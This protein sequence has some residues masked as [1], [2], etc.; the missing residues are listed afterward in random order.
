MKISTPA[1]CRQCKGELKDQ[2]Q[3]NQVSTWYCSDQC[4]EDHKKRTVAPKQV[5]TAARFSQ[6][7]Y[8][9]MGLADF[10]KMYDAFTGP[11]Q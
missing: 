6:D 10:V 4:Y 8:E 2:P 5:A 1:H 11:S 7:M 9:K 3:Q